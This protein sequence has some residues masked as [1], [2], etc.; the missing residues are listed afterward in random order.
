[1]G[2]GG[3]NLQAVAEGEGCVMRVAMGVGVSVEDILGGLAVTDKQAA[4]A[5]QTRR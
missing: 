5:E 4:T 3:P 2:A 1:M